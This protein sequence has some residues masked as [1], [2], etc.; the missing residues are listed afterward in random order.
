MTAATARAVA[1]LLAS[2]LFPALAACPPPD[3]PPVR[4][5]APTNPTNAFAIPRELT[6]RDEAF[7][8][9]GLPTLD[10][11]VQVEATV[12]PAH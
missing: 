1:V 10:A 11:P 2:P 9:D 8:S 12:P 6:L 4:P 5:L 3:A 7:T